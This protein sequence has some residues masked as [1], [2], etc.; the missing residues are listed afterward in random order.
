MTW[1]I[2]LWANPLV[3]KITIYAAIALAV[4]YCLRLWGNKQ[5]QKGE[6]QGRQHVAAD[7]VKQKQAEWKAKEDQIARDAANLTTEKAS[8]KAATEQLAKD[9]AN[10]SRTLSDSLTAIQ[11]ER[12][13]QYADAS[14]TPDSVIWDRIRTVSK[15]LATDTR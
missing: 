15:Q 6:Q 11:R 3:R 2:G 7:L 9:R 8:V 13:R 12:M 14:G 1:L 5:W 10:L 4:L